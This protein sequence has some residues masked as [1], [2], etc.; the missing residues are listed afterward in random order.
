M[1]IGNATD[2][3]EELAASVFRVVL[4]ELTPLGR[5]RHWRYREQ[6]LLNLQ[7]LFTNQHGIIYQKMESSTYAL[8]LPSLSSFLFWRLT[9]NH[10]ISMQKTL[11]LCMESIA[12]MTYLV[13]RVIKMDNNKLCERIWTRFLW[14]VPATA[15]K[16]S[17]FS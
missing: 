14:W 12:C 2:V 7:H 5:H 11:W 9:W 4:L 6:A 10:W 13:I 8:F 15:V 17:L 1:L 3:S 16:N